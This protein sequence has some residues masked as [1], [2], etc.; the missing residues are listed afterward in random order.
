MVLG[1]GGIGSWISILLSRIGCN[2]YLFDYDH[3]EE[4]NMTGQLVR[5]KDLN[6]LKTKAISEIIREF[7]PDCLVETEGIYNEESPVND[8]M[9]CG[10][11]NMKAR[12]LAFF[13]WLNYVKTLPEEKRKKCFFQDG[14]L[15]AELLQIYNIPGDDEALIQ[16]YSINYLFSDEDVEEQDC[17]FKQTSHC[18]AMIAAH[19]TAFLTNWIVNTQNE[20]TIRSVPP[21][22]EYV[23]PLNLTT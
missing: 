20:S 9:I 5:S 7:S 14:R 19:M 4:H 11:D 16:E 12:S 1:Q 8:I 6:K 15:N 22:Y 2:L 13:K 21:V 18:A 3:F 23:I 10:F 17:T